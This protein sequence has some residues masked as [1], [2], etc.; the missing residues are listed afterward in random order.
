MPQKDDDDN[1]SFFDEMRDVKPLSNAPKAD[2]GKKPQLTPGHEIRRL[3]AVQTESLDSNPLVVSHHIDL[4]GPDD[5]LEFRRD[6]LQLGV[7]KKLSAGKYE[8]EARLDLHG[9]TVEDAR[10]EVY[11]FI[12]DCHRYGLR[13]III[14]HGKGERNPDKV[15][16][17]KSHLASWLIELDEVLAFHSAQKYH[18]GAGAVYVML[19]KNEIEKQKNRER[20]GL[21]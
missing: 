18:G 1:K 2:V 17:I 11:Q 13:T 20:H 10:K 6:G 21:K 7:Y 8:L 14:L 9:Q 12:R 19:R 5:I 3:A 4:L 15:A 16:L